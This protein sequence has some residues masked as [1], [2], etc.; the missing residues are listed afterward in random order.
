MDDKNTNILQQFAPYPI[1][2]QEQ[3]LNELLAS[4]KFVDIQVKSRAPKGKHCDYCENLSTKYEPRICSWNGETT[5]VVSF[6]YC[7]F[8]NSRLVEDKNANNSCYAP[9]LKCLAC[10]MQTDNE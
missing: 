6:P 1:A 4:E 7:T 2:M 9:C 8:F 10:L 3:K 5:D